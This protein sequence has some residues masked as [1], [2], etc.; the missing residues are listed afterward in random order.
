MSLDRSST[1]KE[2][3]MDMTQVFTEI[4]RRECLMPQKYKTSFKIKYGRKT[5][6]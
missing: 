4:H 1:I 3:K 5:N 2:L 6:D